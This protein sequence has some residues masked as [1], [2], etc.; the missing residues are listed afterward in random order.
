MAK[1]L[2]LNEIR[3]RSAQFA[4]EWRD[5]PGDERQEAQS[6]IRDLLRVYGITKTKA[7]LYEYRARRSSTGNQGY[8]DALIPGLCLIEMKSA[9]KDLAAAERQAT[10][11]I[12]DLTKIEAPR[13]LMHDQVSAWFRPPG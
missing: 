12:D 10:D 9:G 5:T 11:Y 6:F 2:S 1:P 7:A 8:I 4:V 3:R 13:G